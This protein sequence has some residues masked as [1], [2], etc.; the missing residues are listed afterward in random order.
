MVG[1]AAAR[2]STEPTASISYREDGGSR[3]S[4]NTGNEDIWHHISY[5]T[6][7]ME[8][9]SWSKTLVTIYQTERRHI[10]EDSLKM[11]AVFSFKTLVTIYQY[12][13]RHIPNGTLK[14]RQVPLK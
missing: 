14:Q 6:L 10:S 12:T 3:L 11:L 8:A 9:A 13:W 7:R 1:W 2:S 4:R 5:F